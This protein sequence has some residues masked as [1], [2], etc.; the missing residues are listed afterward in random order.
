MGVD[1]KGR[2]CL[3]SQDK[4]ELYA[5]L[6]E[7]ELSKKPDSEYWSTFVS[8]LPNCDEENTLIQSA[9]YAARQLQKA[10]GEEVYI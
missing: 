3:T 1:A 6:R 2:G 5:V 10:T 7:L 9:R 4:M 8:N